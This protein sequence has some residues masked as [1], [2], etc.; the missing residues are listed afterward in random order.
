MAE[1]PQITS[2][3]AWQM[4]VDD[5]KVVLVDVRTETEWR[6]IG[7][8]DIGQLG[9]AA[10]FVSWTDEQGAA[11]PHFSDLV[12]EGLDP[13]TPILLLCRSGVR[14]NAAADLLLASGYTG[15]H[16][17]AGGFEGPRQADGAHAGGWKDLLPSTTHGTA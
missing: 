2:E 8:P 17:I 10:H 9:R 14:S 12:T 1:I 4:L 6:T 3:Q 11:N 7:V 16:N 5:E 15:A 13:D